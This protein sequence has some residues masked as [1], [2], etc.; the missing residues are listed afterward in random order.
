MKIERRQDVVLR[1]SGPS[2]RK[3]LARRTGGRSDARFADLVSNGDH[4]QKDGQQQKGAN[5]ST[6][7]P[8]DDPPK[9]LAQLK[10]HKNNTDIY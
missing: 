7:K 3:R 2:R 5:D 10:I 9:T 1:I 6:R 4:E 8:P